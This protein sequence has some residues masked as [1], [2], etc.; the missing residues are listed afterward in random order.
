MADNEIEMKRKAPEQS[1]LQAPHSLLSILDGIKENA[2]DPAVNSFAIEP[3]NAGIN[4]VNG[5]SEAGTWAV[6]KLT[7]SDFNAPELGKFSGMDVAAAQRGSL[8]FYSQKVF[9]IG[10]SFLAYAA[11]GKIAGKAMGS[12][13]EFAPLELEV[14][15]FKLGASARSFMQDARV[16]QVVGATAYGGLKDPN[17]GESHLSNAVSTF[18]GFSAFEAGNS[19]LNPRSSGLSLFGQRY[20]VGMFGGVAQTEAASLIQNHTF[21]DQ[22]AFNSSALSGGLLNALLPAGGK[23]ADAV[24]GKSLRFKGLLNEEIPPT[25][26]GAGDSIEPNAS[27]RVEPRASG[28]EPRA[29][30]IEPRASVIEPTSAIDPVSPIKL[31]ADAQLQPIPHSVQ[32]G[33]ESASIEVSTAQALPLNTVPLDPLAGTF[34]TMDAANHRIIV[35]EPGGEQ[36]I[37]SVAPSDMIPV[38]GSRQ[39]SEDMWRSPDNQTTWYKAADG[40]M[41]KGDSRDYSLRYGPN[42]L[43]INKA[44]GWIQ[45]DNSGHRSMNI[46]GENWNATAEPNVWTKPDGSTFRLTV[47]GDVSKRHWQSADGSE[48]FIDAHTA[49]WFKGKG[50]PWREVGTWD[51]HTN[52]QHLDNGDRWTDEDSALFRDNQG[53]YWQST[54]KG[55][56]LSEDGRSRL[57]ANGDIEP[58]RSQNGNQ[59]INQLETSP[60]VATQLSDL[61]ASQRRLQELPV[62]SASITPLKDGGMGHEAYALNLI[63]PEGSQR[64]IFRA[65]DTSEE[66]GLANTRMRKDLAA[67]DLSARLFE[68]FPAG[69]ERDIEI[70]GVMRKGWL[71]DA[72]VFSDQ[73]NILDLQ[74]QLHDLSAAAF[75]DQPASVQRLQDFL[76]GK[77]ADK[78]LSIKGLQIKEALEQVMVERMIFGDLDNHALNFVADFKA[79]PPV[80]RHIDLDKA[81]RVHATEPSLALNNLNDS[82]L[83]DIAQVFSNAKLSANTQ[84]RVSEFVDH[85]D[86]PAGQKEM[87]SQGLLTYPPE[88]SSVISRA[89]WLRDN[90]KFPPVTTLFGRSFS[91]TD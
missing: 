67:Q 85:Y 32:A 78:S 3:L 60:A 84:A 37:L 69:V 83:D 72:S 39:V 8:A 79:D 23:I 16:A 41:I 76:S 77:S 64:A 86:S 53:R 90:G 30:A 62:D 33:D 88:A 45:I 81:F 59:D 57:L 19:V 63:G 7:H 5:V 28:V 52:Y 58:V 36:K 11:A 43:L 21:A 80:I 56:Y 1:Q 9:G 44:E 31:I 29:L 26:L 14:G 73:R 17:A 25:T 18:I 46:E 89:R 49:Q 68:A 15:N 22:A 71:Q 75:P 42:G 55:P 61:Q 24:V 70:N 38:E 48:R 27:I 87:A 13:S 66:P 54:G 12:V 10:G 40:S 50:E 35:T 74:N 20:A 4:A 34:A 91:L 82:G 2:V 6:N 47:D 65:I 51:S